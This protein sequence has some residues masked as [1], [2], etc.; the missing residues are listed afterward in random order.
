MGA[1]LGAKGEAEAFLQVADDFL[2]NGWRQDRLC[3]P[4]VAA[5]SC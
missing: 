1:R 5:S 2:C 3:I 4:F